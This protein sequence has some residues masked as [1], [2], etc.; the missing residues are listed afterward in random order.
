[1]TPQEQAREVEKVKRAESGMVSDPVTIRPSDTLQAA[2]ELMRRSG[3]SGLPVVEGTR[4]SPLPA[5][6]CASRPTC[7]SRSSG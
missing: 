7:I 5:V 4:R 3:V 6:T 2:M 1:M